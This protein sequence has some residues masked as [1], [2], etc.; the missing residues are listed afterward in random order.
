MM[1]IDRSA[2]ATAVAKA[3]AFKQ[4]GKD[5]DAMD[6]AAELLRLLDCAE[7]LRH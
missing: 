2:I 7:L 5:A 4:C 6:W 3:I 1:D